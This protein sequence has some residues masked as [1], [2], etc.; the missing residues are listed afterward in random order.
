MEEGDYYTGIER[1]WKA[2]L[3]VLAT[4]L[5]DNE[6]LCTVMT[7]KHNPCNDMEGV[8][9]QSRA[10]YAL[11]DYIDAQSGGPGKGWFRIVTDPFHAR[12]V[13]NQ[14]KLAVV[15]G[16]EVSRIFGCGEHFGIPECDRAQ[17]DA[18]LKEVRDLGVRTFFPVHE[19]DNAFGGSKMISGEAG[20]VI[21]AGNHFETGSFFAVQSCPAEQQDAEQ[22]TLPVGSPYLDLLNGAFAALLA[23]NPLPVYSQPPHCNTRGLTD[24]GAYLIEQMIKQRLLIQVDHMSSKTADAAIAI[25]ER[26]RYPGVWA[27]HCCGSPQLFRRIYDMGGFVNP[28][29]NPAVAHAGKWQ[30]DKAKSSHKYLFGFGFG[31]DLNGLGAQPGPDSAHPISYPFKSYDGA[32]TFDRE[33]WGERTFDLNKDGLANYGQYADW[34]QLL[35]Q[36]APREMAADMFNGAEAYLQTWERAEGVSATSCRPAGERFTNAGLGS[37]I[38]LGDGAITALYGVG[39]P[40]SRAGRSYRYCVAG[41]S[42]AVISVFDGGSRIA[43]IASTAPGDLASGIGVGAPARQVRSGARRLMA[44]VWVGPRLRG[45]A[46]YLY[47]IRGGRV[48][49]VALASAAELSST[50]RLRADL[51]AAGL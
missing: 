4:M 37:A 16:I 26:Q 15:E 11:Q 39:Q 21:N 34:L 38:R 36:V 31:S 29:T 41:R 12:K 14:G 40:S 48:R 30:Q 6:A 27:A 50:P 1:A 2:G 32:V 22:V 42:G 5:V 46:R 24:L 51:Q 49:Y 20:A 18:G 43:L 17:V 28:N 8:R 13:I 23:G 19:F 10:L 3:R 45:G 33:K 7:T 47:G 44:G 25:A 35:Q 9:I